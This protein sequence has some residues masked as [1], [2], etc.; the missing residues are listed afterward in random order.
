MNNTCLI[1]STQWDPKLRIL[2]NGP[3]LSG[4]ITKLTHARSILGELILAVAPDLVTQLYW[5]SS[6]GL[7]LDLILRTGTVM[8]YYKVSMRMSQLLTDP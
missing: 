6:C 1:E 3:I 7:G 8:Q 5:H 4:L 2:L